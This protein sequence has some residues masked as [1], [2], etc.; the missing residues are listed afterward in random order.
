MEEE[1]SEKKIPNAT[2]GK[3][4]TKERVIFS[5]SYAVLFLNKHSTKFP[6]WKKNSPNYDYGVSW[7]AMVEIFLGVVFL[8]QPQS[9]RAPLL[10][11]CHFS[12]NM[13]VL[14]LRNHVSLVMEIHA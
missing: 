13:L 5:S 12:L 3:K 10:S 11:F 8:E 1:I 6:L 14:L 4:K 2:M 7:Y 9:Q